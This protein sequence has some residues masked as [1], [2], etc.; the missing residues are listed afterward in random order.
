MCAAQVSAI[1][2]SSVVMHRTSSIGLLLA[3]LLLTAFSGCYRHRGRFG[4]PPPAYAC[5]GYG[6]DGYAAYGGY[7]ASPGDF[8]NYGAGYGGYDE[9]VDA[10]QN[11][12]SRRDRRRARRSDR[13]SAKNGF[14]ARGWDGQ[15]LNGLPVVAAYL[16]PMD[17]MGAGGFGPCSEGYMEGFPC[18]DCEP[19]GSPPCGCG[20]FGGA[21][22]AGWQTHE[23]SD[24]GYLYPDGGHMLPSMP[25]P[26]A[27][28]GDWAPP[29][30]TPE[31]QAN[32][33]GAST[34][35]PARL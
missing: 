20:D 25:V 14:D 5:D 29:K 9:C 15:T 23:S 26:P 32:P 28:D 16:I 7:G 10:G 22:D 3:L 11:Y 27:E 19:C 35:I 1:P 18:G 24:P 4:P 33:V 8:G 13:K 12:L 31:P 30:T 2:R 21:S 6:C 34:W 17:A